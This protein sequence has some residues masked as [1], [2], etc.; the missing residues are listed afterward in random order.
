MTKTARLTGDC[1]TTGLGDGT[2][3]RYAGPRVALMGDVDE[4][5]SNIGMQI[6]LHD[7]VD[8][9]G[10]SRPHRVRSRARRRGG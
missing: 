7:P 1:G 9:L 2:H 8:T 4:L 10:P 6:A 3:M 5:N